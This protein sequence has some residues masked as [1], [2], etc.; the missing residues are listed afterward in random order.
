M[1]LLSEAANAIQ[2]TLLGADVTFT[3]VGTDSRS[4][5]KGQ[6]FVALKGDNFD[7]HSF[8][9][10]AIAQGAAAVL[11]SDRTLNVQPAIL[12]DDTCQ[13]LGELAAYWRSKFDIPLAAVT[14]SNGKTTVK[15]ML[16]SILRAACDQPD[17][18]LATVGNLNNHI[19]LPLTLLK[20]NARHR[21]AVAE[22]GMNH[23]GEISYLSRI[24]K[25][26]V[27]LINNAGNAHIGEL[28][29][30]E[31]I[32]RAKGEIFEGLAA[33]ATA[34]I[35]ADDVF[36]PLWL[37]LA[38][39]R[40]IMT[41]GLKNKA[42]VTAQYQLHASAS[43][44]EITTPQGAV[45][46][47]LPTPGLH[48]VMNALAATSTALAM[49]ASLQA[50]SIGLENYAGVKGRL[51]QKAGLNGALVIDDTYN[52]NPMS[53]KV[54]IDVL[55][56]MSGE[57]ILVLGDMGELGD[58]AAEM[59]AEIGSYAKASG[60]KS[61]FVL[62]DMSAETAKTFGAGAKHYTTPQDLV[63]DLRKQ[64]QQGTNVLVKGSRFMAMERVV[65]EIVTKNTDAIKTSAAKNGEEH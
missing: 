18:V 39:Q 53:M 59:H 30:F 27:A 14:G 62:G 40:K 43:D 42:D 60:L 2:A 45:K 61:L 52:A 29:S 10:Q 24:G 31:A 41:F 49:G 20:L 33:D 58:N 32:A 3:S 16:A 9:A 38:G 5:T 13:S 44:I 15:E 23:T 56:A 48:N 1:M 51:Q 36:A 22:M 19:G 8:A 17:A 11:I 47:S 34:V 54:A 25:P 12:V 21:Y 7:G 55:M 4:V 6:L 65:N 37:D 63:T 64:M 57:K 50:V 35:N 28:G 46:V 26:T